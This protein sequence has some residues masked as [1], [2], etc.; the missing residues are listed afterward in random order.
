MN[1]IRILII[2]KCIAAN[3]IYK[4]KIY[5]KNI[6]ISKIKTQLVNHLYKLNKAQTVTMINSVRHN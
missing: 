2:N 5:K 6:T 4:I 3:T 1:M